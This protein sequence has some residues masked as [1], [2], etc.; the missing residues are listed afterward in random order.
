MRTNPGGHLSRVKGL[1]HIVISSQI[2]P[3]HLI[4]TG[5]NCCKHDHRCL[6]FLPDVFQNFPTIHNGQ[7][8]IQDHQV[9]VFLLKCFDGCL[10]IMSKNDS[11]T[12]LAQVK[13][14][15]YADVFIII[16]EQYFRL[17]HGNPS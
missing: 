15:E 8:Q 12:I 9:R 7:H 3:C 16:N 13:I 5:I 17:F 6:A 4:L 10:A 2:E 14:Q 11:V 1:D